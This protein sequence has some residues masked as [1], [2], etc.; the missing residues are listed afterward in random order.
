MLCCY[1]LPLYS[2]KYIITVFKI[3]EKSNAL[4]CKQMV[5]EFPEYSKWY[6]LDIIQALIVFLH[7]NSSA[8]LCPLALLVFHGCYSLSFCLCFCS[9]Y[10]TALQKSCCFMHLI[11]YK[12]IS[13]RLMDFTMVITSPQDKHTSN[14]TSP[15]NNPY[16]N[17]SQYL[18]GTC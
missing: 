3:S 14:S 10:S 15:M 18:L 1:V 4:R 5:D 8:L 2:C 6:K 12:K 17:L 13:H 11:K 9:P 7:F 16:S